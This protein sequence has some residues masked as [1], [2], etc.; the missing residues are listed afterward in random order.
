V[1]L[2]DANVTSARPCMR[3]GAFLSPCRRALPIVQLLTLLLML[4]SGQLC[5]QLSDFTR[6]LDSTRRATKMPAMAAV[7]VTRDSVLV[8]D[9]VGVRR[10]GDPT[11]IT[12]DD[13]FPIGSN[14]KAVTAGLVGLLVDD[15]RLTWGATLAELF[16]ELATLMRPEYRDVT[17][18]DLLTHHSGLV[19][20]VQKQFHDADARADRRRAIEWVLTRKPTSSRGVYAYSNANY[21]VAGAIVERLAGVDYETLV[22]RRLLAP[23]G[24]TDVRFG[25]A[26]T[27]GRLDQP[28]GHAKAGL[29]GRVHAVAPEDERAKNPRLYGPAGLMT[30]SMHDWGLWARAVLRAASAGPSPWMAET[31][32]ALLTPPVP[33]DSSAMGWQVISRPAW[34]GPSGRVLTHNGTNGT[35]YSLAVLAPEAGFGILVVT[36]QGGDDAWAAIAGLTNRLRE[37][38][39]RSEK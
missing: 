35:F 16:P 37:L 27:P 32:A 34:A 11:A 4:A 10:L 38:Y 30:L 24:L 7:I 23:L 13:R 17:L 12:R 26:A 14:T 5:A 6:V 20:Y 3:L 8:Y 2:R 1:I 29:F 19:R 36:N 39:T 18:R 22:V 21:V 9:A 15:G 25:P 28:W 33:R 31:V